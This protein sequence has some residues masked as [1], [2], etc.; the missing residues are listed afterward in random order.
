[1]AAKFDRKFILILGVS[2]VAAAA[3]LGVALA[4]LQ[5]WGPARHLRRAEA[6][7]AEGDWRQAFNFYGR[8]F[9]KEPGN[10]GFLDLTREA[11]LRIV[12]ETATEASERYQNLR[13]IM[14]RRTRVGSADPERWQEYLDFIEVQAIALDDPTSWNGLADQAELMAESFGTGD[15]AAALADEYR[16]FAL[17]QRLDALRSDEL[18]DLE[19]DLEALVERRPESDRAWGTLARLRALDAIGLAGGGR[20]L[21][22]AE[23]LAEAEET[24][25]AAAAANA[26][27][28]ELLLAR[29]ELAKYR[30]A[31]GEADPLEIDALV[32]RIASAA[33]G[34]DAFQSLRLARGMLRSGRVS[35]LQQVDD[36][37]AGHLA[38]A[39][40]DIFHRQLLAFVRQGIDRDGGR[41][42]AATLIEQPRMS[43]GLAAAFQDEIALRAAAQVFDID[44]SD[45]SLSDS[46]EQRDA[47]VDRMKSGLDTIAVLTA[48]A[49]DDS[50]RLRCEAKLAMARNNPALAAA[51]F[52]EVLRQGRFNDADTL[53]H[54]AMAL[55]QIGE[56]GRASQLLE[57]VVSQQPNN[58]RL[59]G[60]LGELAIQTG[61]NADAQ[62][63]AARILQIE[64]DNEGGLRL[65]EAAE[66]REGIAVGDADDPATLRLKVAEVLFSGGKLEEARRV[67]AEGRQ[68]FPEDVRFIRAEAQIALRENDTDAAKALIAEAIEIDPR[69]PLLMRMQSLL[70]T[71]D[72]IERIRM[73]TEQAHAGDPALP[74]QLFAA[75]EAAR[76]EFQRKS[77]ELL[78]EDPEAAR[79]FSELAIRAAEAA[80]EA[81]VGLD[82]SETIPAVLATRFDE[83]V[84]AGEYEKALGIADEA[85]ALGDPS[86]RPLLRSRLRLLQEDRTGALEEIDAALAAGI[87]TS[88]IHRERGMLLEASGR[89]AEALQSYEEALSRRPNDVDTMKRQVGLLIRTGRNAEALQM[90]RAARRVAT[91]DRTIEEAW[92]ALEGEYGDR[93]LALQRRAERYQFDREDAENALGLA[94][95]LVDIAPQRTDVKDRDGRVR[96]GVGQWESLSPVERQEQLDEVEREWRE[97][98]EDIF[99]R[100]S[101]ANPED[102]KIAAARAAALRTLGRAEDGERV[103]R[104]FIAA[105][106]GAAGADVWL[107][108]GS[109]L[110]ESRKGAEAL[111][112]FNKAIE[113]ED[114]ESRQASLFLS[115]F[116]FRRADW[117]RALGHLEDVPATRESTLRRA[118]CL[119]K[120]NRLDEA[121]V[122]LS[123]LEERD[124]TSVL[125]E[126]AIVETKARQAMQASEADAA[127]DNYQRFEELVAQARALSPSNPKPLVQQANSLRM[128]GLLSGDRQ[129]QQRAVETLDEALRLDT[130]DWAATRL[131]SELLIEMGE[132]SAAAAGLEEYVSRQPDVKEARQALVEAQIRADNLDRAAEVVREAIASDPNDAFWHQT[133]GE[134]ALRNRRFPDAMRSFRRSYE[135]APNAATLHRLVDMQLRQVPPDFEGI[136]EVLGGSEEE[137][138]RSIYLQSAEAVSI[139]NTGDVDA[140]RRELAESYRF[141][142]EAI[143]DG[144]AEPTVL[145][146]WF[147]NL[148]FLYGP[149]DAEQAEAFVRAAADVPV[150]PIGLRWLAE[151]AASVGEEGY[152]R[153]ASLLEEAIAT[154]DGTDP[155]ITA[156]L[157]LD[158]GNLHYVNGD[159]RSAIESFERSA[160]SGPPN[161]QTLNN[162]AFLCGDCLDDPARGLPHIERAM[163]ISDQIPEFIDTYGYLLWKA[164]R[165]D[166]AETALLRSLRI[167]PSAL[168]NYHLAEVL[169]AQGNPAQARTAIQQARGLDPDPELAASIEDLEQR[170][171]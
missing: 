140:G 64:P 9:G 15:P 20:R 31:I 37:L 108:L 87:T 170:I 168:A 8:A 132:A 112:A 135:L 54:A 50:L 104:S 76:R 83:A 126:A 27:G 59:L 24:L 145:D 124:L 117:E 169:A 6:A 105:Q 107:A 141:A 35:A 71:S 57:G 148:R 23:R 128:R 139:A 142:L 42:V 77:E 14:D 82:E 115:D 106:G 36:L 48:G 90:L 21:E 122:V 74:S 80:Q 75:F 26:A 163:A 56:I 84:Q 149:E 47:A 10:L 137:V 125:L 79:R 85:D 114:P 62:R 22:A 116:W 166:E 73:L 113:L 63:Y 2:A 13:A 3:V 88:R 16:C 150:H 120:L 118:E 146:G 39:P 40:D 167:R 81:R 94:M 96:F 45:W 171:R 138:E 52:E 109:Y 111:A 18:E 38:N 4:V 43:V 130:G 151:L 154:D 49:S 134:M 103:L 152:P 32:E 30:V 12:P 67:L 61:R 147:A 160:A 101:E 102:L 41:A 127:S 51:R 33:K 70:A 25:E 100:L 97:G 99:A 1:M 46:P 131:R 155:R 55:R 68:E 157:H 17:A 159:C 7:A 5:P 72:P 86:V 34:A 123:S 28:A 136:L 129:M 110:V 78:D 19:R 144:R 69:D 89:P 92:M 164:G 66:Q 65:A 91:L 58:V 133:L 93:R 158:R 29:M 153:G 44:F 165:L 53:Y 119:T 162:L 121:T 95:L 60:L 98:A 156:R 143:A 11:L 161:P